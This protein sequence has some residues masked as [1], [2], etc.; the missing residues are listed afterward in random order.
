MHK[1][2]PS[3]ASRLDSKERAAILDINRILDLTHLEPRTVV[4]DI[5]SGT[6]FF[7]IPAASRVSEGRVYAVDVQSEMHDILSKKISERGIGN[8]ETILSTETLIPLEDGSVDIAYIGNTLHEFSGLHTLVEVSRI[9]R[10]GGRLIVV[11]WKKEDSPM[12]PP[13]VHRLSESEASALIERSGFHVITI[14][15]QGPYNYIIS[16]VKTLEV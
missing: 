15:D 1:F 5:G 7:A 12:G 16:A 4:A 9:L 14:E 2:S 3:N 10:P 11:D 13:L 6:G 8:I